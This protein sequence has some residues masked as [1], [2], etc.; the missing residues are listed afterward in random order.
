[1]GKPGIAQP[2]VCARERHP[3]GVQPG[4]IRD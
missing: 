2:L 3:A 1:M 4:V